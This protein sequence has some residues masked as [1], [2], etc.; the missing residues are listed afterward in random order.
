MIST[1]D[2]AKLGRVL[3]IVNYAI[4]NLIHRVEA[5]ALS[6]F[7]A[8]SHRLLMA[9]NVIYHGGSPYD[10]DLRIVANAA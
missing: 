5:P 3:G 7:G 4:N 9:E 1:F 8:S 2:S 6:G 10:A